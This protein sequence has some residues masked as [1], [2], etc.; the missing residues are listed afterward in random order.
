MAITKTQEAAQVVSDTLLPH[1]SLSEDSNSTIQ[2]IHGA[3]ADSNDR[4]LVVP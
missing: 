3:F 4:D 1:Q 2:F